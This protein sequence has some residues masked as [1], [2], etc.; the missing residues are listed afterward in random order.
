VPLQAELRSPDMASA[1]KRLPANAPGEFFVDSSCID[2]DACRWIAPRTFDEHG[3]QSRVHRQPTTAEEER[4]AELALVACPTGSIGTR[5]KRDLSASR[6]AF[7]IVIDGEVHHCG[8]HAESSFGAASYLIRRPPERGGN[9]LVDSPRFSTPLVK[10]LEALGGVA[11]MFLTHADD[12]A[13]H[14]RFRAHFGCRRIL[15]AADVDASTRDVEWQLEGL[16]AQRLDDEIEI[17]PTPGHTAGSA[18]LLYRE[19][20]L[21]SGDHVAWSESRGH[22]YAFRS[23]CWFDWDEQRRSMER[24]AERA[25]EWILPG[26]GRRCHFTRERMAE[27]MRASVAWMS[28]T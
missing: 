11:T 2:C 28:S 15:H 6:A 14:A 4:A 23:A 17:V 13:D 9:L 1:A 22:V 20:Y 8:Y 10:R 3:D 18:C 25:F 27:E 19:T 21:F 24:L 16:A 26:H 12:V 7:P 5:T